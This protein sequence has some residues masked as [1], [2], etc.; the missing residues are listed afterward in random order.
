MRLTRES[1]GSNYGVW[2][3]RGMG[4]EAGFS[5]PQLAEARAAPV[6]MTECGWLE[7][8]GKGNGKAKAENRMGWEAV[9]VKERVSPLRS[10]R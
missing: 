3:G 10:S 4:R 7:R 2:L 6:E 5:A 1:E 9:R 8:T